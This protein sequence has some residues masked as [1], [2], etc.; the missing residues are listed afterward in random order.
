[1]LIGRV[2]IQNA[3]FV[4]IEINGN[5]HSLSEPN[6]CLARLQMELCRAANIKSK[7]SI[8]GSLKFLVYN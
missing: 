5:Y 7:V 1:M 4:E 8:W 3:T 2:H 6:A